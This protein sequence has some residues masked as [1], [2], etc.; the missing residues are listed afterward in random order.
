MK[1]GKK[2]PIWT[3]Y[4]LGND[5]NTMCNDL[6][7]AFGRTKKKIIFVEWKTGQGPGIVGTGSSD[8]RN[9]MFDVSRLSIN[10][11]RQMDQRPYP[12]PPLLFHFRMSTPSC[13]GLIVSCFYLPLSVLYPPMLEEWYSLQ[14]RLVY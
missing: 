13:G 2:D 6:F 12:G 1:S 8:T 10:R 3:Q 11:I 5:I 14:V 7:N 4:P 9:L